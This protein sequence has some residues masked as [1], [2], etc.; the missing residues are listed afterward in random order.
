MAGAILTVATGPRVSLVTVMHAMYGSVALPVTGLVAPAFAGRGPAIRDPGMVASRFDP[1]A[2]NPLVMMPD[3]LPVAGGPDMAV[4]RWRQRF[5]ALGRG[6]EIYVYA[7]L[8]EIDRDVGSLCGGHAEH[9]PEGGAR[10]QYRSW[11]SHDFLLVVADKQPAC[12]D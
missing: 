6:A 12:T 1:A 4:P 10:D 2:R 3:S 5:V 11:V 9:Q 7:Q 8:A